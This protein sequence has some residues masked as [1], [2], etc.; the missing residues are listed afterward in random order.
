M[1]RGYEA[2]RAAE[3]VEA[4]LRACRPHK[5]RCSAP[6]LRGDDH[7]RCAQ[8]ATVDVQPIDALDEAVAHATGRNTYNIVEC[9][10]KLAKPGTYQLHYRETWHRASLAD[11]ILIEHRC[12]E[13]QS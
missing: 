9:T 5:C 2:I 10:G 6:C 1:Q 12:T 4:D 11:P 3:I 7:D 13:R 8:V